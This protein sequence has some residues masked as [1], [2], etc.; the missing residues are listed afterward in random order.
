MGARGTAV[1]GDVGMGGSGG[2]VG[3]PSVSFGTV[4]DVIPAGESMAEVGVLSMT[5]GIDA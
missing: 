3:V 2:S 1:S 5:S 4:G